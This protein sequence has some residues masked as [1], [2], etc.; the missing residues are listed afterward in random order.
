MLRALASDPEPVML[1]KAWWNAAGP[2]MA[3]CVSPRGYQQGR[4]EL[5]VPGQR[6]L[7]EMQGHLEALR[8]RLRRERGM[9]G[10]VEIVLFLEPLAPSPPDLQSASSTLAPTPETPSEIVAAA[11]AIPDEELAARW[12]RVVGRSLEASRR[13]R[14]IP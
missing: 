14:P 7:R 5:A 2:S 11:K 6:W 10:L 1:L 3:R 13:R 4:L 12:T 8:Q 9:E